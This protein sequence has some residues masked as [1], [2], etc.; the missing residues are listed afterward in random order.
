MDST[1]LR[2]L[3][4][5]SE[6]SILL[7]RFPGIT[8]QSDNGT[9]FGYSYFRFRG[10]DQSR[11]NI[12]INGMPLNEPE[13]RGTYFSN[14]PSLLSNASSIQFQRGIGLS[15]NGAPAFAGSLDFDT[16]QTADPHFEAGVEAGSFSSG[17]LFIERQSG[18]ENNLLFYKLNLLTTDGY[19][20]HSGNNSGSG[21]FQWQHRSEKIKIQ[22][23][24]LYGNNK[25]GLGW[26]GVS[27]SA[28]KSDFTSNGNSKSEEGNFTQ[29]LQQVNTSVRLKTNQTLHAGLFYN[30]TLGD[31]S[32]DLYNFLNLS[33]Q[34]PLVHYR[35]HSS[36][37]GLTLNYQLTGKNFSFTTG[38]YGSLY[39]KVHKGVQEPEDE[40]LYRNYGDKNELS[41]FAKFIFRKNN[42]YFFTDLQYR[43]ALFSYTGDAALKD[44]RWNFFN[45]LAGVGYHLNDHIYVYVNAGH[46][47]REPGRNDIFL[48][49]DNLQKDNSGQSLYADL[50]PE[51]NFS[52][53]TGIRWKNDRSEA[54]LNLYRMNIRNAV[55]LNGQIGPTGVPLHSNIAKA[56]RAGIEAELGY[57]VSKNC[58]LYQSFSWAPHYIDEDKKHSDPVLTPELISY[59][60]IRYTTLRWN[61]ALSGRYQSGSYI[62]FANK[63]P[64][65][66]AVTIN[67]MTKYRIGKFFFSLR[68]MNLLN[69]KVYSSGQLNVY[70]QPIYLVQAPFNFLMG[71]GIKF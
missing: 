67:F 7:Q 3:D 11:I 9:G 36:W 70:G 54:S 10:L 38:V 21:M 51:D 22:L 58:Q 62:D 45:P 60:E 19:K 61:F 71:G 65:P 47:K 32:F 59:S 14:F 48:G 37:G 5:G 66:A 43:K 24:T 50:V 8:Y 42:F 69:Q 49:N 34:G 53:E 25:N 13:D 40:L 31:Y 68:L 52:I 18:N 57:R 41:P 20:R 63:Y 44:F 39:R 29:I 15:K 2:F 28:A 26:L 27:D 33:G 30:Y 55:D 35:T 12:T 56:I 4:Y 16:R 23:L 6:P 46:V 17:R 64:I 1:L